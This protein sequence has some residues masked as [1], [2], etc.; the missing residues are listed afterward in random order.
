MVIEELLEQLKLDPANP[1]LYLALARAYLDSG[2]EVKARDLAVRYHRQSGADPQLWRGWAE[3]CQ[4]LGMARQAQ[5]CYEQALRLAPQDWEAMYG[6]AVLLAN[7]GHYEKSLHYLRKIIRGHPEHQA[8]RVLLADNYR[9]LGLPGQAEVL[10]PAAEKTSV[11]LPP[12]YFP[13]AISSADT[14]IFLQLFAGREIGYALHQI[15][16]LTG[17]PG[18]V[19]QEAPVNP[20]LIIRHLQGDLALA[21]YPL[22]TDNTARYAAVT[23]RLPARVWEANLKNQGY[24][25]YQEEKLR[26]QVLALARYA[27]Q[28]NIPAYPEERGAY[29]FRL[30]FFFTD[31]VHFLKIKDFVTRFL[32]HVPQPEP[33]FVVEPILAT[34]SVGIGW[35]ERAVALPLGIHPATR[36]RSLF[37]DAEGRPY[38]EQLKIL[39]K[40][41]PIPLPTALAGL[42]AAASPQ[43]VATDQRLPLSK[44][45]KSLAQQCPVLDE[46]INKAL[47]GR[48][49]R[50]PEK[51]ILFYTVGLIDRTG[52][53]LHQLLE[54]SPDYQYQKVQR[55]FS[56]LSANPISCYKIRQ[57]L[58]EITASVNCNCSFDLRGGKYPSPLLHVNPHLVPAIEDLMAPTKLPLR[59]LARRYINLRRQATEINQ[60][61]ERL[62]AALDEELTRQGLDSLQID[63][64]KLRRVRQGQEIRWEMESE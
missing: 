48:V 32:E 27:R 26:H 63:R 49:L 1:C 40:I 10:I 13:P 23:L 33:G 15:D 36:R 47:R 60:A 51:I 43:A 35:T 58:P 25:T 44:G 31:F 20:D 28:R 38:A 21:A 14:A 29:Q 9:A 12:R 39:R 50:R 19:Y 34:Q 24:L 45:I 42:R 61:L 41:R 52:Q 59:E 2:A 7:V 5:T 55:Q 3:V 46:L 4:A 16:A 57:L 6:L 30:W 56:R 18:Y 11:T 62:A 64:T 37:L 53:G 17:Q 8:A 54:T 22:R